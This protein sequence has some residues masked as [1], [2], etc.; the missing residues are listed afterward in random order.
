MMARVPANS[1]SLS[2]FPFSFVAACGLSVLHSVTAFAE[3][4]HPALDLRPTASVAGSLVIAGGGPLP[5]AVID[6][7]FE[8]AG[9]EKARIVIITTA[10]ILAGTPNAEV[11]Y[12]RWHDR[13]PVSLTFLHTRDRIEANKSE[14]S[15]CL[16]EANAVWFMG[17]NQNWLA[18]AYLGTLVE[19]R[20]HELLQRN[21]VIGGTSAGAAIMSKSMIAGGRDLPIMA[22]GFGF[23]EGTVID[24]H[25]KKRNRQGRLMQALEFRP[26]HVGIG[27]DESTALVVRGRTLEVV[28]D[29][30]VTLTLAPS[31]E[32]AARHHSL[33]VGQK[34]DMVQ[35]S[36][37]A[38]ARTQPRFPSPNTSVPEV[39]AGTLVIVGGGSMPREAVDQFLSAAGGKDASILVVS[40]ALSD[41][42]PEEQQ[43]CGWLT[44]AGAS[45]V[46][47]FHACEMHDSSN[48]DLCSQLQEAKGVW[49]TGGRQWRL[50]DAYLDTPIQSLFHAV[51]RR[52]GVIGGT[53]AG[54][55]IQGDYLVRGNPL[56]G[57]DMMCEGYERGFGFLP[58]VA[59][60]QDFTQRARFED[61][62][63]LKKQ[64]PQLI[65]LGIDEA[66]A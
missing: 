61:M 45:N 50:V 13:K 12:A 53:S 60:D 35:L 20:C 11:H 57:A 10:S 31:A 42:P 32:R 24:Q 30:D 56:G 22:S 54:A 49:F 44:E 36:R 47:Q 65:G 39:K 27:I 8:L 3:Q 58:G 62:T 33:V 59:I 26:G 9:G 52:G 55:T 19:Q 2:L 41:E 51:L 66:T 63:G 64:F 48:S 5:A 1:Q 21:G 15:Q 18:E 38:I 29:S 25:F 43:V 7:Y 16:Q 17:G 46:R 23:L 14:F 28:G 37:A 6:R 34:E 4:P 40:N